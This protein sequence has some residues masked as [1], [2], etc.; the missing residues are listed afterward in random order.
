MPVRRRRW[1]DHRV[2]WIVLTGLAPAVWGTTYA[3]TSQF[4]PSGH[5]LFAALLR[6]LPVGLLAVAIT[7]TLPRG[8][9]WWKAGVLGVLNI[10]AFFPLLFI[11]AERLPG[12]V[13]ATLGAAQPLAV[14]GLAVAVLRERPSWWRLGWGAAG[15]VGVSLVVLS[16]RAGLD[17]PGIVAGLVGTT[18]VAFGLV[19][20]K[21]WG[22]PA[23]VGPMAFAGWLLTAGGLV[24][25]PLT[26]IVE[27]PPPAVDAGGVAGYLWLGTVG[28]LI[29]YTLWFRGLRH[30]PVSATALLVL[31]SPLVAALIG[32]LALGETF[33]PA[34][35]L[36]F[37]LALTALLAGQFARNT[38]RSP[39][40]GLRPGQHSAPTQGEP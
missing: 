13:A 11:A 15:L 40:P 4:L 27:G 12:G 26:A 28:G 33:T 20:T 3:V 23:G 17:G 32:V 30:L 29:A 6:S 18:S 2:T 1:L 5:P 10:G 36:G 16:P 39:R 21:R 35:L 37:T 22:A 34:Q 24:L 7:R 38:P 31:L 8:S 25:A 19:L 9:W 14:A